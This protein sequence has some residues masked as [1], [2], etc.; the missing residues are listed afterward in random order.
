MQVI[1]C[2]N[3]LF[4]RHS[5]IGRSP[6]HM[7]KEKRI[8]MKKS[9]SLRRKKPLGIFLSTSLLC[10]S[11]CYFSFSSSLPNPDSKLGPFSAF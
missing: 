5:E 10:A 1:F 8:R 3:F 2:T 9:K 11:R 6:I 4:L 7:M